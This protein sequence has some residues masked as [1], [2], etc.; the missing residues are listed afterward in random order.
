[1]TTHSAQATS[2]MSSA[3]GGF[4]ADLRYAFR[5]FRRA[6]AFAAATVL[7]LALG[8]GANTAIFSIVEAVLLRP[9][10]Y[11]NA[12]RLV[13]V[14]QTDAAHRASGAYFNS[15]REFEAW[16]QRSR[17]FE[18][19]AALT[20]ATD[21]KTKLWE[22]KPIDM[23]ALPASVDF[24]SMLGAQAQMGRTFTETDLRNPCTLVLAYRF[25]QQKLGAPADIIGRTMVFE[26]TGCT[27]IGVMPREFEFYPT[28]T[29]AWTL[30]TPNSV[31]AQQPWQSMTG[32]FGLLKPGVTRA[33]AEAEL[34]SIQSHVV[35]EAPAD[36]TMMR[37]FSPDV[38]DLQSNFTWLAGRNLRKGLW[39]LLVASAFILLLAAVNVG[40]LMLGRAM[41]REREMAVR[42]ALG[43]SRARL[44]RQSMAESIL[45]GMLG[46]A[47]G[48]ALAAGLLQW[49]RSVNPI[50]LPPAR[51]I[52][53]DARA[54]FFAAAI[55]MLSSI[56]FAVLPTWHKSRINPNEMLKSGSL[57]QTQTSST[58]R[59]TQS[60]VVIQVAL[61]M[62]LVVGADMLAASLFAL[63]ST[64]LGYR[65]DH[66]FTAT[67]NLPQARYP[68]VARRARFASALEMNLR[69][70][71][72]VE[73]VAVGS[74]FI[75]RGLNILSVAG[76]PDHE[77]AP[78]DVA[79]Q[80]VSP[81]AFKTLS[82]PLLRGR[83]FTDADRQNTPPVAIINEALAKEYFVGV[84]P[85]GHTIKL[86]R[87]EDK[88]QP[89]LTVVG[90]VADVKTTTV[91]QEMG[92]VEAP[93]VYRPLAQS[94]PASL[95]I[96]AAVPAAPSGLV[97]QMQQSLSALDPILVLGDVDGMRTQ[98][99]AALA[100]PRFR[101]LLLGGFAGLALLLAVVGLYAT[102]SQFVVR[103]TREISIRMALGAQRDRILASMLARA[104][105]MVCLGVG[106]GAAVAAVCL[107]FVQGLFYG[108]HS[109]GAANFALGAGLLVAASLASALKPALRAA[110]IE[111]IQALRNE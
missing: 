25:W 95:V 2:S 89:W 62:V 70:L 50:E 91:F 28:A 10:P 22:G 15:Y 60:L 67:V 21:P 100:Q 29:D 105:V 48:I 54:L 13:V 11:P 69:A 96:M 57:N 3:I 79:T 76:R 53:L 42:A 82:V 9:L 40:G 66:L 99:A 1:V 109:G 108:I 93:A 7:I 33:A 74:D 41:E 45:L 59:A 61:S 35:N 102:L 75:P 65:T 64:N 81:S 36:L 106:L 12:S 94:G 56:V 24:F 72:G 6:R 14:W 107:R 26:S 49:F 58:A 92:Y 51:V 18:K 85:L 47:A 46:T 27:I 23:L 84:D 88:L 71:P 38:L 31:F 68:D 78:A 30:I 86:S 44:F 4:F 37:S 90:V 63:T 5:Q 55:G 39:L 103:R 97:A 73:L 16:R 83:L 104:M 101:T 32:A 77:N 8:I 111:P 98:R 34:A 80:D 52:T 19:L 87:G 17:S 43:S 110:S 20:W